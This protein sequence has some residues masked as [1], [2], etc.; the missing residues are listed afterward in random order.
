MWISSPNC[1]QEPPAWRL[2][3]RWRLAGG[4]TARSRMSPIMTLYPSYY[5][6]DHYTGKT[7]QRWEL[8]Q[9]SSSSPVTMLLMR[10]W[11]R[12]WRWSGETD[13]TQAVVAWS[14]VFPGRVPRVSSLLSR[15][16]KPYNTSLTAAPL[17][18]RQTNEKQLRFEKDLFHINTSINNDCDP[19]LGSEAVQIKLEDKKCCCVIL[20]LDVMPETR[21]SFRSLIEQKFFISTEKNEWKVLGIKEYF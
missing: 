2:S 4:R 3:I 5:C 13:Q 12:W 1:W 11:S 9:H 20:L 14:G 18:S 7:I 16:G 15:P 19:S 17:S 8:C 10:R 6:P 21:A